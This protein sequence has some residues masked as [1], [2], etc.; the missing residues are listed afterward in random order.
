MEKMC[1]L[2]P[3]RNRQMKKNAI[4]GLFFTLFLISPF[5]ASFV[6][7]RN[8]IQKEQSN[9]PENIF[10]SIDKNQNDKV[11]NSLS[12]AINRFFSAKQIQ[13]ST[14]KIKITPD[15][16]NI[17]NILTLEMKGL[18]LDLSGSNTLSFNF[19]ANLTATYKGLQINLD[20]EYKAD[21]YLYL[22]STKGNAIKTNL[23]KTFDDLFGLLKK[24]GLNIN[25]NIENGNVSLYSLFSSLQKARANAEENT[26]SDSLNS[27]L[28]SLPDFTLG[29][30]NIQNLSLLLFSDKKDNPTSIKTKDSIL[31]SSTE[32]NVTT[33]V[34][35]EGS[36]L[37]VKEV[38]TYTSHSS[39][40]SDITTQDTSIISLL[41]DIFSGKYSS[42]SE[43]D[44]KKQ[45][46][47]DMKADLSKKIDDSTTKTSYLKGRLDCDIS[48]VFLDDNVGEYA[49]NLTQNEKDT[50]DGKTLNDIDLYF[51]KST[52]YLS[53]NNLFKGRIDNS[54][55]KDTFNTISKLLNDFTIEKIDENLNIVFKKVD[56]STIEKIKNGDLSPLNGLLKAYHFSSASFSITLDGSSLS[57]KDDLTLSIS[58]NDLGDDGYEAKDISLSKI[59]LGDIALENLSFSVCNFTSIT[60]PHEE[61]YESY[62]E[63]LDLFSSLADLVNKKKLN[64]DYSLIFT[65]QQNVTF[66][67]EGEIGVDVS[68]TGVIKENTLYTSLGDYYLSLN[69]PSDKNDAD[70]II[71]QGIE[72]YYSGNDKNLYFG[73][74]Y[75]QESDYVFRNSL[76]DAD[77]RSMYALIDSK[78]QDDS[79]NTSSSIFSMS[80]I[81]STLSNSD[82]FKNLKN[83]LSNHLSLK[84]LDGVLSLAS[85]EQ[86]MITLTLD[87]STFFI[88]S[89]YES[90]TEK[91]VLTLSKTNEI[92][93]MSIKGKAN[94]CSIAFNMN[95]DDQIV[96]HSASFNVTDYP[97]ITNFETM[98]ES[99]FSLPT[100]LKQF[101]LSLSGTLQNEG[102]SVPSL[103]IKEGSG[104]SADLTSEK[105]NISGEV[106]LTHKDIND[107][108]KASSDQK[109]EFAL[110]DLDGQIENNS[111]K[112]V[113]RSQFTLEY[114]DNMHVKMENSD[115]YSIMNTINGVNSDSNLLFRYLKFMNSV[116]ETS[117]S[118]LMDVINGKAL[119]TSGIFAYKYLKSLSFNEGSITLT[120]DP[121]LVKSDSLEGSEA[122]LSIQYDT[123]EKKVTG[124]SIKAKY[125]HLVGGETKTTDI[126]VS[127]SLKAGNEKNY[128]RT[129]TSDTSKTKEDKTMLEYVDNVTSSSFVDIDGFKIL[130]KCTIDTTENN[131]FELS[132]T[133]SLNIKAIGISL[134]NVTANAYAQIYVENETAYAYLR[135]NA[136]NKKVT[137]S[138]NRV[139]EYF[140]KEKE[141]LVNQTTI[142]SETQKTGSLFN[143]KTEYRYTAS[144]TYYKTT[145][146]NILK[147]IAYYILDYSMNI[148]SV[149]TI[150]IKSG[151]I[152]LNEIY[153]AMNA[154]ESSASMSNDFST[155]IK[156]DSTSYD[157]SS[158]TFV[159]DLNLKDFLNISPASIDSL[160]LT[161]QHEDET[162]IN[163]K[164]YKPLKSLAIDGKLSVSVLTVSITSSSSVNTFTLSRLEKVSANTAKT[165]MKRYYDYWNLVYDELGSDIYEITKVESAGSPTDNGKSKTKSVTSDWSSSSSYPDSLKNNTY[166]CYWE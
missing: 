73:Y 75:D 70:S 23:P 33:S 85:D 22:S 119:S 93:S 3:E 48:D 86:G 36:I 101:D 149:T 118:P 150:G 71:G 98:S 155:I 88:G 49:L 8:S 126:D 44:E 91:F 158:N 125:I 24:L 83:D 20:C 46:S 124:A 39:S 43:N 165:Y 4:R 65:D 107:S 134:E 153:K 84:G 6:E 38:S 135:I 81:L 47:I 80:D 16:S 78:V 15:T 94:G 40:A 28:V 117:G 72:M 129:L 68:K 164:S 67:G 159:L 166:F 108:T 140:I 111:H 12:T 128:A 17:S 148:G 57:L 42:A 53:L 14:L 30:T 51:K 110:Q 89:K 29:T 60:K 106:T 19:Y 62:T 26:T 34:S 90:N 21:D 133:L 87:P 144:S 45:F 163:G 105:K 41:S 96:D 147:N 54:K 9:S 115:L 52:S 145:S 157:S 116:V 66:N 18:D 127:L 58:F 143:R 104:L 95:F 35:L 61:D 154:S 11:D 100:D 162:T 131:F 139:T 113:N 138:G 1:I 37:N 92:L 59:D 152:A 82:A 64:V 27:F 7:Q 141:V 5:Q 32:K 79:S 25:S 109:I 123:T 56:K 10:P 77:I 112:I 50:F 151:N 137:D 156:A 120:L 132:G 122:I 130:L 13:M 63:S 161:I 31:L 160:K 69:L 2:S 76:S 102:D 97:P 142:S 55:L 114:N 136:F 99:L 146:E 103:S 74:G 121:K